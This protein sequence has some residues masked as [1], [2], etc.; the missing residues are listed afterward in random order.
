MQTLLNY[1][2]SMDYLPDVNTYLPITMR[3]FD[4]A[5]STIAKYKMDIHYI[6]YPIA[7]SAFTFL[8]TTVYGGLEQWYSVSFDNTNTLVSDYPFMRF[9]L[10]NGLSFVDPAQCSSSTVLPF[11]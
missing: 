7:V 4:G 9:I 5:G 10:D 8:E 1:I 11:N 3:T 6:A 2:R